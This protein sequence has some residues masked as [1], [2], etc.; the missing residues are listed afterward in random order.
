[1]WVETS[2]DGE[3]ARIDAVHAMT[4]DGSEV[5][6]RETFEEVEG[7]LSRFVVVYTWDMDLVGPCIVWDYAMRG[8]QWS[9]SPEP[10][11]DELSGLYTGDGRFFSLKLP[12][13]DGG[14]QVRAVETRLPLDFD[15]LAETFYP[16]WV[17]DLALDVPAARVY[18]SILAA[19]ISFD[20]IFESWAMTQASAAFSQLKA[21]LGPAYADLYPKPGRVQS[22][23]LRAAYAPGLCDIGPAVLP[24]AET[25]A[26]VAWDV[27]SLYPSIMAHERLPV[28]RPWYHEGAPEDLRG[29][30][31]AQVTASG[32]VRKDSIPC[33]FTMT[34]DTRT[35]RT[36]LDCT[37]FWLTSVDYGLMCECYD[38]EILCWHQCYEF[39]SSV[40]DLAPYILP[41]YDLK[42]HA[43]PA[44]RVVA[45]QCLNTVYGKFGSRTV[46]SN[47]ALRIP[48]ADVDDESGEVTLGRLE[49]IRVATR[50]IPSTYPALAAFVTAYGRAR[51]A[52][53]CS[54]NLGRLLYYDTDSVIL[55]GDE[56]PSDAAVGTALGQWSR[57]EVFERA[58]FVGP[59]QYYLKVADGPDVAHFSGLSGEM[60]PHVRYEEIRE[61]ASLENRICRMV[62]GGAAY[63]AETYTLKDW[64]RLRSV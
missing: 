24:F 36:E 34:D 1:M 13:R 64:S 11:D 32:T 52:R 31:I 14:T 40:G 15:A 44:M 29:L 2:Y 38:V 54:A 56:P 50:W 62:P 51:L 58:K 10:S 22:D 5:V 47:Q 46:V 57:R 8:I 35:V 45:K 6:S 37:T 63:L 61:G 39:A 20:G 4:L 33:L 30:W 21:V 27:N 49:P 26:G 7:F 19:A 42:S 48:E 9:Q 43:D 55:L 3:E 25:T 28:G 59:K 53:V 12:I 41:L 23:T 16:Q 17:A 18:M 60:L